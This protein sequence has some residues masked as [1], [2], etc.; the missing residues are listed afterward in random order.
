M[1]NKVILINTKILNPDFTVSEGKL[2]IEDGRISAPFTDDYTTVTY[3]LNGNLTIPGFVNAHTHSA[4][5]GL[6]SYADDLPLNEWLF[7]KVFPIEAKL[8]PDDVYWLTKLAIIEYVSGGTTSVFDMYFHTDA[9]VSAARECGFR[10]TMCGAVND[11]GGNAESLLDQYNKYNKGDDDLISF[12]IGLHAEY[13]TKREL[14]REVAELAKSLKQPA[15]THC[16]ETRREVDE[17]IGRYGKSPVEVFAEDGFFDYGGGIFHGVHLSDTDIA[18]LKQ[19]NVSVV[20]NPASNLKLASGIAELDKL[21]KAGVR[22]ALGTDG[23]ASNN[24]LS[25]FREMYLA[26]ALQK[27]TTGDPTVLPPEKVLGYATSGGAY[28]TGAAVGTLEIGKFADLTVIN[29]HKPNTI[30]H[31]P[32]KN[33]VYSCDKSNIVLTMVGGKILYIEGEYRIGEEV[34]RIYDEVTRIAD[35]VCGQHSGG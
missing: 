9:S 13:T 31:N 8:T 35:R 24:A 18:L 6:R 22:I 34:S 26:S 23:A 3:D 32:V 5:T 20:S 11:F 19:H 27:G 33:I 17:C 16:S 15:F 12:K 21:D 30:L 28:V 2:Y 7:D 10:F 25:M 1:S 29:L 14:I 4:M